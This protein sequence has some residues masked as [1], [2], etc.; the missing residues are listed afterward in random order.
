MLCFARASML[1]VG[2]FLLAGTLRAAS[3]ELPTWLLTTKFNGDFRYRHESIHQE[4]LLDP[5]TADYDRHRHRMRFRVGMTM[6]P[7]ERI[8]T[9][10]RLVSGS[11]DVRSS[12]QDFTDGFST[13]DIRLDRAY[14]NYHPNSDWSF[15]AGKFALPFVTTS[16]LV[17]D[18]DI[19]PEG[20]VMIHSCELFG[21]DATLSGGG[22]WLQE[23]RT[24][25]DDQGMLA[26]QGVLGNKSDDI[27]WKVSAAYYEYQNLKDHQPFAVFSG[28]TV[29]RR[30]S[31]IYAVQTYRYDYNLL[32]ISG[33]AAVP[34]APNTTFAIFFE[35]VENTAT[36]V[37]SH[38]V[39]G[40]ASLAGKGGKLPYRMKYSYRDLESD[41]TIAAFTESDFAAGR[42]DVSGHAIALSVKPL[43]ELK[44]GA[45]LFVCK[46][47]KSTDE[48]DYTRLMVDA[49]VKF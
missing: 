47:M 28:N 49:V 30:P 7:S 11:D 32:N 12:N 45:T 23:T 5:A 19:S 14:L 36:R 37:H 3:P 22:F 24:T 13:K 17:W 29:A 27:D 26:V 42:T 39:L 1:F 21:L 15:V 10:F 33:K 16:Q 40:G 2:L 8:S 25:S 38:G 18:T 35:V 4:V 9:G 44:L 46:T 48:L 41:A 31:N 43:K 6:S 34:V 20:I